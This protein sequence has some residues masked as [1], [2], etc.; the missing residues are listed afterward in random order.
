MGITHHVLDIASFCVSFAFEYS[1]IAY[2][3][4][5]DTAVLG[6]IADLRAEII[7]NSDKGYKEQLFPKISFRRQNRRSLMQDDDLM[8]RFIDGARFYRFSR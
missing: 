4:P 6:N 3:R 2:A 7:L 1:I 8:T 5:N